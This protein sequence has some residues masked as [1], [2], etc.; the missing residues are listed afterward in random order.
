MDDMD[1]TIVCRDIYGRARLASSAPGP[2]A[3]NSEKLK[4]YFEDH[5]EE[6]K[7]LQRQCEVRCYLFDLHVL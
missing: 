2:E 4:A 7:A 1:H 3:L 6:R 5:P